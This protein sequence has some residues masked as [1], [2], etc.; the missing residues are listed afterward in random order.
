[1]KNKVG[2]PVRGKNFFIRPNIINKIYRRLNRQ[3]H[4]YLAAPRRVGKTSIMYYLEDKPKDNYAFIYV[5]T[6]SVSGIEEFFKRLFDALL[7]SSAVNQLIKRS[8]KAKSIFEEI[9]GRV[10]KIG[11]FGVDFE[12]NQ[13]PK[14]KYSEEFFQLVKKLKSDAL[15]I[16]LM[17]D[18]F[19]STVENIHKKI[20]AEE[21]IQFLQINRTI[22]QESGDGLLMI[23]TG[24]IGLPSIVNR[25]DKP[26]TINDLNVIEVPPLSQEEGFNFTKQLLIAERVEF[27]ETA[28]HFLLKKIDWLMPFFIQLAVQEMIDG[29]E[30]NESIINEKAVKI[31]IEQIYKRRNNIHFDSYYKRLKEAFDKTNYQVAIQVLNLIAAESKISAKVLYAGIST[32]E[33]KK[34][35]TSVLQSLEYDGYITRTNGSFRFNSPVLKEWWNRYIR[36]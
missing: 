36:N 14:G 3:S 11:V 15:T 6:E 29:Y 23:Y 12:L 19:P 4:I 30:S 33:D 28:I 35:I 10:K 9:I 16:V 26:E 7:N 5:N 31:A 20:T 25:L 22:R 27:E 8:D 21:A 1:M 18:E 34:R 24:S 32:E 2:Q 13:E 17:I